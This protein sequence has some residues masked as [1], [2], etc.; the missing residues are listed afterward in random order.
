MAGPPMPRKSESTERA[1]H[2]QH[3]QYLARALVLGPG[4]V[5]ALFGLHVVAYNLIR[6]G[7]LLKLAMAVELAADCP[8]VWP[9][10][11]LRRAPIENKD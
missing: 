6:L 8:E 10:A 5:N 11:G 7:N 2:C 1:I 9:C 3:P 4:K